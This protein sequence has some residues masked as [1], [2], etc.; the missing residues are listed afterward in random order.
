MEYGLIGEHLGQSFSKI[1]HER[2]ALYTYE[3]HEVTPE[4]LDAFLRERRFRAVNVTIPY[5]Q[6]VIP[7]LDGGMDESARN[8]GAVNVI[9]NR[10]G[11]LFGANTD[12]YGFRAMASHA[13]IGFRGRKVLILGTGGASKAA[14]AAVRDEGASEIVC[15]VRHKPSDGEVSYEQLRKGCDA[16]VLVN[17]TPVGMYPDNDGCLVDLSC[18]PCLEGVL[19]CV[20]NPLRTRL[21]VEAL[22][23][24]IRADGGLYMLVAQA[25]YAIEWFQ[26]KAFA[27]RER[28]IE[29]VYGWLVGQKTN[30]VLTGMPSSGKSTIGVWLSEHLGMP[31]VDTDALA[32]ERAGMSIADFASRYGEPAFRQLEREVVAEVACAAGQVIATGGGVPMSDESVLRLRQNGRIIFIDRPLSQLM[33]TADRPFSNDVESLKRRYEERYATYLA[34]ADAVVSNDGTLDDVQEKLSKLFCISE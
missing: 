25:V 21:V 30:I 23:R 26:D 18:F 27:D 1:I 14:A 2:I 11:K 19:D 22:R 16:Q 24:G 12:Y 17:A 3:P 9:V 15:A 31:F 33:P 4:G 32:V 13:G 8:V 20:A 28:V 6:R 34:T 7:Y 10:D 5:K 29:E